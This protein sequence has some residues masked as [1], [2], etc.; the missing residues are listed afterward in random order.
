MATKKQVKKQ[1][2]GILMKPKVHNKKHPYLGYV[3]V[4][5]KG[6]ATE[7]VTHFN[8]MAAFDETIERCKSRDYL[9]I[10]TTLVING[11]VFTAK[12][13]DDKK[14]DQAYLVVTGTFFISRIV[15]GVWKRGV[16]VHGLVWT[17]DKDGEWS[18]CWPPSCQG[19][20]KDLVNA[21]DVRIRAVGMVIALSLTSDSSRVTTCEPRIL[22]SPGTGE[23]DYSGNPG[24][25]R[26]V[27]QF[28]TP[29]DPY[30]VL[31]KDGPNKGKP[32]GKG[33][34]KTLVYELP[35]RQVTRSVRGTDV[36]VT[37]PAVST[38]VELKKFCKENH[39][40]IRLVGEF[41]NDPFQENGRPYLPLMARCLTPFGEDHTMPKGRHNWNLWPIGEKLGDGSNQ[42]FVGEFVPEEADSR[43]T[44]ADESSREPVINLNDRE[45][46][47][48]P[49]EQ[50]AIAA[51][52][53]Q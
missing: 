34:R 31:E 22:N 18:E 28:W 45:Q 33:N 25:S 7:A 4:D 3:P 44:Q 30:A 19:S 6:S 10:V 47:G 13:V 41:F 23:F 12:F 24:Y 46:V 52:L 15:D 35:E 14:R 32:A 39:P 50:A 11:L 27:G 1:V 20:K 51:A 29:A 5:E 38:D 48:A 37:L 8:L 42:V 36:T 17:L 26:L 53:Q 40:M 16:R 49:D 2:T 9:S 43:P 21:D